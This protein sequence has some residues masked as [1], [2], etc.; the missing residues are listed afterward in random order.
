MNL[1]K[2][3]GISEQ[4]RSACNVGEAMIT[5]AGNLPAKYVI[6]SVGQFTFIN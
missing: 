2:A 1:T 5:T 4:N 3:Y 6:H